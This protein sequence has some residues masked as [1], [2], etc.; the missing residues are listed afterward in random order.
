MKKIVLFLVLCLVLTLSACKERTTTYEKA[1]MQITL[2]VSY[3]EDSV[4]GYT[5]VYRNKDA[6]VLALKETYKDLG[7][8]SSYSITSY[9]D[10]VIRNNELSVEPQYENNTAKFEYDSDANGEIYHY[11]AYITKSSDAFWV[12]QFG[13]IK[14]KFE[15][16][17]P[18]FDEYI[19]TI[20]FVEAQ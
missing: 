2:N 4:F 10:V 9:T 1:G 6:A 19:S 11:Y 14:S 18:S 7:V 5:A 20:T 3:F 13:S 12:F 16:L 17:K 8:P 15:K